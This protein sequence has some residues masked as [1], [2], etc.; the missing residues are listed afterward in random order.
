MSTEGI[1]VTSTSSPKPDIVT[2]DLGPR[3]SIPL[4]SD[5]DIGGLAKLRKIADS[6]FND[7]IM[8]TDGRIEHPINLSVLKNL[9]SVNPV[10]SACISAKVEATVGVGHVSEEEKRAIKEIL[11]GVNVEGN[12]L[13]LRQSIGLPGKVDDVLDP[14]CFNTWQDVLH[15]A[16]ED[17]N[18]LGHSGIEFIYTAERDLRGIHSVPA[19]SLYI[20][21]NRDEATGELWHYFKIENGTTNDK[22][23]AP[24]GKNTEIKARLGLTYLPSE[25]IHFRKPTSRSRYYG[26][27]DY[28]ACMADIELG[29][30]RNQMASDFFL[31]RA[32]PEGIIWTKKTGYSTEQKTTLSNTL[33]GVMGPGNG[34]KSIYIDLLDPE[35]QVGYIPIMAETPLDSLKDISET[36]AA[37]IVTSHRVPHLLAGVLTPGKIAGVN[38]LPN[39]II[40]FQTLVVQ[41]MQNL[42]KRMLANS[43]GG[44]MGNVDLE[45]EDFDFRRI[46]DAFDLGTLD[47]MN[48]MKEP[49]G[50]GRKP[51]EGLKD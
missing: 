7:T 4:Y 24:F 41:P 11:K 18:I 35:G 20:H 13:I 15:D 27:P 37:S 48:R 21:I 3:Q 46:T 50:S 19:E 5:Q 23:I 44:P 38:E 6:S 28:L 42:I 10:H 30:R 29:M 25:L 26:V 17:Y 51:S 43:L 49:V 14:H 9:L 16:S 33:K 12:K 1:K 2:L 40:T 36:I 34:Y 32:V 22:V 31:N 47:T 8:V 45:P 39:A